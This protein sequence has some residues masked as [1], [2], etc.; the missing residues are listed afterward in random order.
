M[1]NIT[2]PTVGKAAAATLRAWRK[3][4]GDAVQSGDVLL[5]VETDE[6]LAWI[7]SPL[8]GT[9]VRQLALVGQ[10]LPAGAPLA[11]IGPVS[12]AAQAPAPASS[13]PAAA[14][15]ARPTTSNPK[16]ETSVSAS[17]NPSA[18]TPIV[19]PQAGQSMEEGTLVK[20]H[21]KVGD[22][23]AKGQI[24]FEIETDKATME[25]EAVDA[26]RLAR[27][28]LPDGGMT[29]VKEPVGFLAE[30]D[31][32]VDAYLAQSG[33]G[34]PAAAET[35][36]DATAPSANTPAA[37]GNGNAG[38]A[39]VSE[40]GRVRASPVARKIA[41][42][43]GVDL[44]SLGAGSG[45]G[46]RILSTDV[47]SAA[48]NAPASGAPAAARPAAAPTP[49]FT[50]TPISAAPASGEGVTR[51]RMSQMRKIIARNLLAS[52]Q[53]IPHFYL[54][55]TIDAGP[56]FAFYQG[57]KAKYPVSLNDVVVAAV[58][59]A[60]M[61]FP[62]FRSRIEGDEIV[63]LPGANIGIAVGM[64]D[65]LVV[66]VV[67][68]AEQRSLQQIGQETKRI[69]VNARGGKIEGMGTG[70]FTITNLGMFGTD[71]FVGI[72]NPPEAGILAV[73][74]V[75][76]DVIVSGGTL[77]A[78]RVMTMTLSADHRV[79]DG[80]LAAKFMARLKEMLEYP[81]QLL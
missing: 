69:A 21:V 57:E 63:T 61:E 73:G 17:G 43:K 68:S 31:A 47:L 71:E 16:P 48:S 41:A 59:R 40:T 42:D 45:P 72:I 22:R 52:K 8:A 29:K 5:E 18:V 13:S 39:V 44:A 11:E 75:R 65:G 25:V 23:I 38:P 10:T 37:G 4:G 76:E 12:A 24:I 9:L 64:D 36:S 6:G 28:V 32:D 46:G 56:L 78:G 35:A 60:V 67:A 81:Q 15:A 51:K 2:L 20:W 70:V 3:A 55:L 66:P 50:P 34:A 74:A 77:R 1:P 53:N 26:G 33:G 79:V 49:A 7:E 58:A 62:Q 30:N 19:M 80:M 54:K 27:I 14:A